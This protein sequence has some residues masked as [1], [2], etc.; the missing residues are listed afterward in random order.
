MNTEQVEGNSPSLADNPLGLKLIGLDC[1][2]DR[3]LPVG[4]SDTRT[5]VE[6]LGNDVLIRV[7]CVFRLDNNGV[8]APSGGG[9]YHSGRCIVAGVIGN[10]HYDKIKQGADRN[11][12]NLSGH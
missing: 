2:C 12:R 8:R 9:V 6:E 3:I 10:S 5:T 4:H 1:G 7:D 11:I